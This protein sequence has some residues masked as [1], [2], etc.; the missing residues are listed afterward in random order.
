MKEYQIISII[1]N[2]CI[3]C[4]T[5]MSICSLVHDSKYLSLEQRVIGARTRQEKEFAISCDL[6]EHIK[7]E[8]LD[9]NTRPQPQCITVCPVQAIFITTIIAYDYESSSEALKRIFNLEK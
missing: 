5:C 4:D 8:F 3:N 2:R 7:E 9:S 6:C 1:P